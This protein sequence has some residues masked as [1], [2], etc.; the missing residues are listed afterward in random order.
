MSKSKIIEKPFGMVEEAVAEP[1]QNLPKAKVV[2]CAWLIVH[3][4]IKG[5]EIDRLKVDTIVDVI[6]NDGPW[7]LVGYDGNHGW[8]KTIGLEFL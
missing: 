3:S 1:E 2:G 7:T 8:V 4:E 6:K 5:P